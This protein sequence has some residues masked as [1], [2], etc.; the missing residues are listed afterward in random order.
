[1]CSVLWAPNFWIIYGWRELPNHLPSYDS[2]PTSDDIMLSRWV[3]KCIS[4][5]DQSMS[6]DNYE[7]NPIIPKRITSKKQKQLLMPKNHFQQ[8]HQYY[9]SIL[10]SIP[11]S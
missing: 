6:Y 11:T 10:N 4:C 8:D 2:D 1:M 9:D 5:Y 7:I 3:P